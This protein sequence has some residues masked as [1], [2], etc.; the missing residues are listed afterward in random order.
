MI[1]PQRYFFSKVKNGFTLIE[2]M[3]VVTVIA[4]VS[5]VTV[6]SFVSYSKQSALKQASLDVVSVLR[7]AKY[8]TQAQIKPLAC[9]GILQGYRVDICGLTSSTCPTVDTYTLTLVCS[10]GNSTLVT[11]KLPSNIHFSNTGTTSVSYLF[12]VLTNGVIGAGVIAV[13]GYGS[14]T[15]TVTVGS[16]GTFT[17]Q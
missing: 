13:S 9:G 4:V 14:D 1:K 8:R 17:I 6:A 3:V 2:L 16:G 11:K 5:T 15:G 7:D 12:K 10:S